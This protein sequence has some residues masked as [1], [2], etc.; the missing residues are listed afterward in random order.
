MNVILDLIR[1]LLVIEVLGSSPRMT[2]K[3]ESAE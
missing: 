2:G 1:D 3:G